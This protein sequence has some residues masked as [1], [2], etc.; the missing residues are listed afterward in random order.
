MYNNKFNN[1]KTIELFSL[2]LINGKNPDDLKSVYI[3]D[4]LKLKN[5]GIDINFTI[6]ELENVL[7]NLKSRA[8]LLTFEQKE[9]K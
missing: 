9:K 1:S 5:D 3:E 6:D 8:K 2:P 7:N 4:V